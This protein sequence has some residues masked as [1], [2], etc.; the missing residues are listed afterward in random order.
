MRK[1]ALVL[2]AACGGSDHHHD[3]T[4]EPDAAIDSPAPKTPVAVELDVYG[5]APVLVA[6]R[7]G[8]GAW[9]T[10]TG[11]AGRYSLTVTDDYQVV[12][13]CNENGDI[14]S[15]QISATVDDGSRQYA[16]CMDESGNNTP[17]VAVT[18]SM[19]QPGTVYLQNVVDS[20]TPN[21][22]VSLDV[23]PGT[24]DLVAVDNQHR[25]LMR[26]G[27]DL[28]TAATL[29]PIDLTGAPMMTAYSLQIANA[30][31]DS[32]STFLD[33]MTSNDDVQ[34]SSQ[35]AEI[36]GPP[37][38]LVGSSDFQY[39]SAIA[40]A[41]NAY[42]WD[43]H[44]LTGT[45]TSFTLPDALTGVTFSGASAGWTTLPTYDKVELDLESGNGQNTISQSVQATKRWIDAKHATSL[46]FDAQ[47]PGYQA[48]WNV[49]ASSF[50]GNFYAFQQT[51]NGD[52]GAAIYH[53]NDARVAQG[54][55][56]PWL[57]T[58]AK[59][60]ESMRSQQTMPRR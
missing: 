44:E 57:S 6:Y 49:N 14:Q 5:P 27:L 1:L 25:I 19:K 29:D 3:V 42:R 60:R 59:V 55:K 53:S 46:A 56:R 17:P 20:T 23:T 15:T 34:W 10:P 37:A 18:G 45:E 12:V 47:P 24:H 21:W 7:D 52:S 48:S 9:Q 43:G 54:P 40:F 16:F 30:G 31:T 28:T 11:D 22:N 51:P 50:G 13:A 38:S 39:V 36:W 35:T 58:V 32:I 2:L 41:G 4:L 33:L 8:A 26:R